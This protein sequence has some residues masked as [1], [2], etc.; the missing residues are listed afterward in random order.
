MKSIEK[1]IRELL[2]KEEI[3]LCNFEFPKKEELKIFLKDILEDE[4]DDKYYLSNKQTN[5]LVTNIMDGNRFGSCNIINDLNSYSFC[6]SA[7]MGLGGGYTPKIESKMITVNSNGNKIPN[8]SEI[9]QAKKNYSKNGISPTLNN[10]SPR[11]YNGLTIRKLTPK[12]CFRLQ[13]FL[14]DEVNL[15]GLSNTQ[16]YKLAGNGQSVNVVRKIFKEMFKNIKGENI[17]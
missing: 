10:W 9:G 6:L 1:E 4:V 16:Q 14:N 2:K 11:V 7:S 15:D 3:E 8:I 12:E 5:K 17:K 13:G